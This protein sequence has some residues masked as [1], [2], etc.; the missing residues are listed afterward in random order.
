MKLKNVEV[1]RQYDTVPLIDGYPGE[2][3]QVFSNLLGNAV[4]A[5]QGKGRITVR[6]HNARHWKDGRSGVHVLIADNGIGI[7]RE[8]RNRIFE[9]FFTTKGEKGTGLGL[10]VTQAIVQKHQGHLTL[11]SSTSPGRRGTVFV[12][13]LPQTTAAASTAARSA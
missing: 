8:H 10:W 4:E 13:F 6:I 3:R 1:D 11:R 12:V 9:P 5:I 7:G 2:L